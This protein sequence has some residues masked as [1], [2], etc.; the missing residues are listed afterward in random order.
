MFFGTRLSV[1]AFQNPWCTADESTAKV[2]NFKPA[3]PVLSHGL[4]GRRRN[5]F[6]T[7]EEVNRSRSWIFFGYQNKTKMTDEYQQ[8][9]E[10]HVAHWRVCKFV[11]YLHTSLPERWDPT[12]SWHSTHTSGGLWMYAPGLRDR[13]AEKGGHSMFKR[14]LLYMLVCHRIHGKY[15]NQTDTITN[16]NKHKFSVAKKLIFAYTYTENKVSNIHATMTGS[17]NTWAPARIFIIDQQAL[18]KEWW[19]HNGRAKKTFM[20][21]L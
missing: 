17:S 16:R 9:W 1:L 6:N 15:Q 11:C 4:R 5:M 10:K 14:Q 7:V 8:A 13:G 20:E 2:N 19:R 3:V 18:T 12:W 21:K